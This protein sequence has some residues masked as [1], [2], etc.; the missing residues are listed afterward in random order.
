MLRLSLLA[1]AALAA[2]SSP[3]AAT[4]WSEEPP[5]VAPPA[6]NSTSGALAGAAA[7]AQAGATTGP[8]TVGP[9]QATTGPATAATGPVH[10]SGGPSSAQAASGPVNV[11]PS[12]VSTSRTSA[13][14]LSLPAPVAASAHANNCLV[15]GAGGWAVGWN[16]F[17]SAGPSVLEA[18]ICTLRALAAEADAAC[19]FR[20]GYLLRR[21]A[22][23]LTAPSLSLPEPGGA[24]QDLPPAECLA[25]KAPRVVL[26][27]PQQTVVTTEVVQGQQ[28]QEAPPPPPAPRRPPAKPAPTCSNLPQCQAPAT[29]LSGA[30]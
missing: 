28:Q 7:G 20:T 29:P 8:I 17:S 24:V 23:T 11:A 30:R 2:V 25:A 6:V 1:V 10:A 16:F 15:A 21:Q 18:P 19:Q 4:G 27:A 26:P 14:A 12:Q 5:A 9:V 22:V 3:A 13:L